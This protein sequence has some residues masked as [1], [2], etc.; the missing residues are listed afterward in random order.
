MLVRTCWAMLCY[1]ILHCTILCHAFFVSYS[2]PVLANIYFF[3]RSINQI[4]WDRFE[5]DVQDSLSGAREPSF[6]KP[7]KVI[8]RRQTRPIY[9]KNST[10]YTS[11]FFYSSSTFRYTNCIACMEWFMI[12]YY[13]IIHY[14]V[15]CSTE[16][17]FAL[18]LYTK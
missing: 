13:I 6:G 10:S 12:S 1:A 9:Y 7:S 11:K 4:R 3:I 5:K 16:R 14:V 15:S 18:L 17:S 8:Y 2:L